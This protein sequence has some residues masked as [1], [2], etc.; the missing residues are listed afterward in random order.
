MTTS[1]KPQ[2][3]S[4]PSESGG[5]R[6][7][8]VPVVSRW[9]TLRRSVA[10][11]RN[12]IPLLTAMLDEHGDTVRMYLGGVRPMWLT[13]DAGLTQH[14]LQKNARNYAKSAITRSFAHYVGHG[15]LTNEGADWLRQRRLI[16]PGFHR[17]R[18]AGLSALMQNIIAETLAPLVRQ[19][20]QQG[21]SVE[22]PALATMTRLTFRIIMRSV[23]ST[24]L[25]EAELER[26]A[27][28]ITELQ[29]FFVR[30]LRQPYLKPW[31]WLLGRTRYHD[32]VIAE[33][34]ALLRGYIVRRQQAA[35][36]T[37]DPAAAPDDLLQMLLDA[38]YEDSGEPMS[39]ERLL[40]EAL[41]LVIAG[42]ETSANALTWLLRLLAE[43][44]A[45]AAH[46][47]TEADALLGPP[48]RAGR[49]PT[50]ADLP[51]LGRALNAVQEA[52]RLYP[53][54]WMVDRVALADDEYQGL[55]I[56]KG[57][58]FSIYLYALHH[59]PKSWAAPEAFR[60]A[61]FA[62]EAA[63][64]GPA[65]HPFAYAPFGGGPRLCI[66]MQ[67]ALT[68]MQLVVLELLRQF[69]IEEVSGQP[70]AELLPLITLRPRADFQVRL[71]LR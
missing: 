48:R 16:Q 55:R 27:T 33:L 52:L 37:A 24:S 59:D 26:A 10:M 53:P 45:E 62:P 40:D 32:Q 12:P 23:F 4:A 61:R 44:P 29:A 1:T 69:R 11:V 15:L 19:A 2:N 70:P 60:P 18:V 28:L 58:L 43:H 36:L 34:R 30:R 20:G 50:F 35:V 13:R 41:I 6:A 68:E 25:A 46:I 7:A 49:A 42:H 47:Q 63:D 8:T 65:R 9:L 31:F 38:R 66:G 17:Q 22:I 3:Q 39:A 57:T 64:A 5:A 67:F 14:V 51:Q 71:R 54:A 56:P 21:G